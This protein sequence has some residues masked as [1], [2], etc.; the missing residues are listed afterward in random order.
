MNIKK[1]IP[2]SV[3]FIISGL[4]YV[5]LEFLWRGR[6]HWTMFLCAGCCG[7]VMAVINNRLLD[8]DTDFHIQVIVSALLCTTAELIF[9]LV[10]NQNFTIWDYRN[11]WGTIHI[12]ND[13]VNILFIG[14]WIIISI[15]A[16]PFL[17]WIQWKLGLA[18]KPYYRIGDR[19][20]YPWERKG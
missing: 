11:T 17:D 3:I 8:F 20:F 15:F 9:G 7:L 4:I 12:L 10:F 16:L 18:D 2:H 1:L 5:S 19:Y 6:S 14:V 13:Q